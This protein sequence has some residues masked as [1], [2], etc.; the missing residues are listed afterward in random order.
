MKWISFVSRVCLVAVIGLLTTYGKVHAVFIPVA[1]PD[2]SPVL[3][4]AIDAAVP[5]DVISITGVCV[6]NVLIRNKDDIRLSGATATDGIK[7]RVIV[8]GTQLVQFTN[9]TV[10]DCTISR[11]SGIGAFQGA[12]ILLDR[13]TSS[14]HLRRGVLVT[15]HSFAQIN[16]GTI[17]NNGR[18]GIRI[19]RNFGAVI[20]GDPTI[21]TV[22]NNGRDGLLVSGGSFVNIENSTFSNNGQRGL[23]FNNNSTGE[24]ENIVISSNTRTALT[25][26]DSGFVFLEDSMITSDIPD[27]AANRGGV[28]VNR[29]GVLRLRGNTI[30]NTA[31]EPGGGSAIRVLA[32]SFLRQGRGLDIITSTNGRALGVSNQSQADLRDFTLTGN[33]TVERHALLRLRKDTNGTVYGNIVL[34]RDS[35]IAFTLEGSGSVTVNGTVTCLDTESSADFEDQTAIDIVGGDG[36]AMDCSGYGPGNSGP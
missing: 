27:S 14:G 17:T 7:G 32:G 6:E 12:S 24:L 9:M 34:Q 10:K 2:A 16:R 31:D 5:G 13:V 23:H 19:T 4:N 18:E 33:I 30:T 22:S 29:R 28:L 35:A 26:S 3:Q 8:V 25:V 11:C 36:N 20:E 21:T 15:D 1:C